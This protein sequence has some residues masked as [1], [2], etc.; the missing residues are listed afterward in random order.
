C[1]GHDSKSSELGTHA[2]RRYWHRPARRERDDGD[3]RLGDVV[4]GRRRRRARADGRQRI[5]SSL[6][7]GRA[8]LAGPE[9]MSSLAQLEPELIEAARLGDPAA[10]DRLLV[11]SQRDLK[12][13]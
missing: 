8:A 10:L 12:R 7:H 2:A 11:V 3:T 1:N 9:Q 4:D 6:L 13:F 5:L